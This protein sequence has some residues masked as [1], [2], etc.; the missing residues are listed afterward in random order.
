MRIFL[1]V[2]AAIVVGV[3]LGSGTAFLRVYTAGWNHGP[4]FVSYAQPS[5]PPAGTPAPAVLVDREEYDFGIMD[6]EQEGSHDFVFTNVGSAPLEL[7]SGATTCHCTVSMVD[8]DPVP[9]GKSTPV[10]VTWKPKG[11]LGEY[12]QSVTILANDP[13]RPQITLTV[14]GDITVGVRA[15]P[16]ELVLSRVPLGEPG[17]GDVRLWCSL[18]GPP[19]A[20]TGVTLSD[21]STAKFFQVTPEPIPQA[22]VQE[23]KGARSGVLLRVAVKPGLPQGPFQQTISLRTN[24]PSHAELTL[25]VKGMVQSDISIAGADWNP[26]LGLVDIGTVS[27]QT[28]AQRRV[29]LVVRGAKCKEV[30]FKPAGTVPEFLQVEVGQTTVVGDGA[31]AHTPLIIQIPPGS[32]PANHLG[33]EEGKLG[34]ILLETN[35]PRVPQVRILVRFAVEG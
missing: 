1:T 23:E 34:Q 6:A 24:Q 15:D 12:T 21:D 18:P 17:G 32:R 35:H 25:P 31:T 22:Q 11:K 30:R 29:V 5:L 33:S 19:L 13:H 7:S 26:Q 9:P 10:T 8:S 14:H 2:V 3:G 16:P 20:I 28:G 27:G 4:V